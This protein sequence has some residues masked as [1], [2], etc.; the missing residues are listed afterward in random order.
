MPLVPMDR[1][2]DSSA[3]TLLRL[4][5]LMPQQYLRV[6]QRLHSVTPGTL[7]AAAVGTA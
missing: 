3:F 4:R 7:V 1:S 5:V 2:H 6:T